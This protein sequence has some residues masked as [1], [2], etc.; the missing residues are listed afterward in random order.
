MFEYSVTIRMQ[1]TDAAGIA[2]FANSFILA[3]ESYE[4]FMEQSTSIAGILA[5]GDFILPIVHAAADYRQA[6]KLGDKVR[7]EL[8][9]ASVSRRSFTLGYAFYNDQGQLLVEVQTKHVAVD[10]NTGKVA[11]LPN[12][13]ATALESL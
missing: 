9:L 12:Q 8:T 4:A 7:I 5:K 2:F 3:H 13:I 11:K 10:K 6:M 1:H